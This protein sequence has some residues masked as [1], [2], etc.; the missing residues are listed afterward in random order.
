[1]G[2]FILKGRRGVWVKLIVA[3][4]VRD[5]LV[6]LSLEFYGLVE[7]I[8][9][10][11]AKGIAIGTPLRALDQLREPLDKNREQRQCLAFSEKS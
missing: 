9:D 7:E 1:V 11:R 8:I 10:L 2:I 3:W 6:Y 5:E 4:E